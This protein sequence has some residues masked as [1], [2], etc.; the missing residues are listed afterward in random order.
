M[1]SITKSENPAFN[2]VAITDHYSEG[3]LIIGVE[4]Y[5][6]VGYEALNTTVENFNKFYDDLNKH[7]IENFTKINS[8]TD[9]IR[10][11]VYSEVYPTQYIITKDGDIY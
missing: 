6:D 9:S 3:A 4:A 10:V 5:D 11:R 7:I 2:S 1:R 8:E